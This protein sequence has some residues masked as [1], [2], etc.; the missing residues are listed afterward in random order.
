MSKIRK[1]KPFC[2]DEELAELKKGVAEYAK[3][4]KEL[5]ESQEERMI[6]QIAY[7]G[8]VLKYTMHKRPVP[9]N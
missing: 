7:E 5:L 6:E 1:E 8:L 9:N 2:F 3:G 4:V